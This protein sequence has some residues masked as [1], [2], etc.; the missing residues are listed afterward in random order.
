MVRA[1]TILV[2]TIL[3]TSS[4]AD[5]QWL[6][7]KW[8]GANRHSGAKFRSSHK[9]IPP[10]PNRYRTPYPTTSSGISI[11][12]GSYP[13][14]N[15]PR[16]GAFDPYRFDSYVYDPYRSGSF[17]APDLINDPYFRERYRYDSH[18]PGRRKPPLV[19]RS[20]VPS[21][22]YPMTSRPNPYSGINALQRPG[23]FPDSLRQDD[24]QPGNQ[25]YSRKNAMPLGPSSS[26]PERLT[27]SLS[28]M[29]DGEA[30][31]EF[32]AP[33]RVIRMIEQG[34]ADEL[35]ELLS[36]YDGITN[37]PQ[38]K[39]IVSAPGFLGTRQMLRQ[40]VAPAA[41]AGPSVMTPAPEKAPSVEKPL[42]LEA[43]D[44]EMLLPPEPLSI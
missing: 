36:H 33:D 40:H 27:R 32:L 12:I 13:Y 15:Y 31:I 10:A 26:A 5:A 39:S 29:K 34:N 30:W 19:M 4:Q 43:P 42:E 21:A 28:S 9:K 6:G 44:I 18:F 7:R 41:S 35:S 23:A 24:Y 38:F 25:P 37:N 22:A 2:V 17:R 11:G 14:Y 1:T 3:V 20:T 16:P 8:F